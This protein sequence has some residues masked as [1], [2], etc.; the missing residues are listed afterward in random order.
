M[1]NTISGFVESTSGCTSEH[2]LEHAMSAYHPELPHGAGLII[3]SAAYFSF[4]AEYAPERFTQM[5]AAMGKDV[6]S[7]PKK[8]RPM[9]FIEALKEMQKKCGVD[10]LKM[11]D[12]GIKE[13]ELDTL[14]ENAVR[15]MGGL[16]YLDRHKL[17]HDD[18]VRIYKES[19]K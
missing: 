3:V 10:N 18:V 6:N 17:T 15:T 5:A 4:F 7:V 14:A 19:F 1:A 9:L 11:S 2:S 12:Y 13:T 16:F 8:Q